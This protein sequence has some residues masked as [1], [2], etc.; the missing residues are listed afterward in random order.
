VKIG[1]TK[2]KPK[3]DDEGVGVG[4]GV[5]LEELL[6]APEEDLLEEAPVV[7]EA[8]DEE[9]PEEDLLEE[10]PV[11][12]APVVE[13]AAEEEAPVV[14]EA[15]EEE[16]ADEEAADDEVAQAPAGL[17]PLIVAEYLVQVVLLVHNSVVLIL[18]LPVKYELQLVS[19]ASHTL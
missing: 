15:A 5:A 13:E 8:P 12:D 18:Q 11:E 16:A 19:I 10:A 14:D 7:E 1:A 2:T 17:P 9:A 4:A 6:E 3:D